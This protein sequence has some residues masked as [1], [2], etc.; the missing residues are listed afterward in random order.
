[1]TGVTPIATTLLRS[2]L[3][4]SLTLSLRGGKPVA[5]APS[6]ATVPGMAVD[7]LEQIDRV[8]GKGIAAGGFP[9]AAVVVGRGNSIPYERAFGRLTYR[10]P[11]TDSVSADSTIY[12][13]A[14]MTKVVGTTTALMILYDEGKVHL[15]DKVQKFIPEFVGRWK[16]RVTVRE[17]LEHRGG[18]A[19]GRELW[20]KARSPKHA[21]EMVVTT[22]L[23]TR[24]GWLT[25]YSD[26]GADLLGWVVEAASGQRLDTFLHDRVF[27]PLGMRNTTF[28]PAAAL[29]YR[30]APT[31]MFPPRGHPIR[32]EVHDENAYVL[33]GVVGHA[34]LFSTASDLAIFAQMMLNR[35][36]YHGVRLIA[37]ST[38]RLFTTRVAD[39]RALGWEVG[40]GERGSGDYFDERAYG[41][42]GFTGTSMWIDP[43]RDLFVILLTNRIHDSRARRPSLVIADV[44]ADVADVAVLSLL[45]GDGP[46]P[47]M[48]AT[49]RS[50]R[51]E[52][53]NSRRRTYT[54]ALMKH[55]PPPGKGAS[56]AA[57]IAAEEAG[58]RP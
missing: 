20:H 17:L 51:E 1:M 12:D 53:W 3:L 11:G 42:T 43:T 47:D 48:P 6:A 37:D 18:L 56:A 54:A 46:P 26:M 5:H 19:P 36:E 58:T 14:S 2:L 55:R 32:G 28:R 52:D 7:R 30:I 31:E 50:D 23:A 39:E 27:A 8:I 41:H 34:G 16:D 57:K 38:V 49:L 25:M 15:D 9:G 22:K 10:G 4:L 24:P 40:D 29:K 21:R 33:G 35:G 45:D 13:I 44:R